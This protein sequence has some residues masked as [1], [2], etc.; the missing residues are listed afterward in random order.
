M[1]FGFHAEFRIT[2]AL[3]GYGMVFVDMLLIGV[4]FLA[5]PALPWCCVG[6]GELIAD[7]AHVLQPFAGFCLPQGRRQQY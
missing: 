7:R 6:E 3:F 5:A 2:F 4:C 1:E